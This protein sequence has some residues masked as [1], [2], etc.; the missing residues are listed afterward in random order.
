MAC[1]MLVET[2]HLSKVFQHRDISFGVIANQIQG[3]INSLESMKEQDG[4]HLSDFKSQLED[5]SNFKGVEINYAARGRRSCDVDGRAKFESIRGELLHELVK[6]LRE[7]FP[8]VAL[9]DA[10]EKYSDCF[11]PVSA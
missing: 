8:N 7:R 10:M 5:T 4:L 6:N 9:F 2:N 1:D 11:L 3:C